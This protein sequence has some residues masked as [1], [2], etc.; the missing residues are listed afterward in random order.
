MTKK[1][2][3]LFVLSVL[4]LAAARTVAAQVPIE[5]SEVEEEQPGETTWQSVFRW[6]NVVILFGGLGYLLGK[7]AQRFFEERRKNIGSGMMRAEQAQRDAHT[8][9][10]E[11]ERRLANLSAEVAALHSEAEKESRTECEKILTEAKGEIDRIV[12]QSHQE[13]DRVTRSVMRKIKEDVADLIVDRA[14][15]TLRTEMT[16]D[17]QKRVVV[18]FIKQL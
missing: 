10:D 9:M 6:A 2:C 5:P 3:V 16:E 8:R 11:I 14:S 1:I 4:I 7:P 12:Q 15:N 18:R 13:I 17:D